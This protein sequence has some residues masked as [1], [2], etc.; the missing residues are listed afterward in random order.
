MYI[1][2]YKEIG[3]KPPNPTDDMN[4]NLDSKKQ[5]LKL[6]KIQIVQFMD[7]LIRIFPSEK[8]LVFAR[9]LLKD[10]IPIKKTMKHIVAELIP[11]EE[12]I[13]A[14]NER[15]FLEKES[16]IKKTNMFS[17]SAQISE[18][19]DVFKSLWTKT[20]DPEEKEVIWQWFKC[21][22]DIGKRYQKLK[23]EEKALSKKSSA[24]K[25][26]E[27]EIDLLEEEVLGLSSLS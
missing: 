23:A 17:P 20:C 8:D 13:L 27:K 26:E 16:E 12:H 9:F 10:Q 4:F 24:K 11:L 14:K 2:N 5:I 19:I 21:F 7:E 15:Y 25:E 1:K 18:K 3:I 6:L 22:L